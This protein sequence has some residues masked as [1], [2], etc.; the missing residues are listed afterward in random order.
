[1][2]RLLWLRRRTVLWGRRLWRR[3]RASH[4]RRRRALRLGPDDQAVSDAQAVREL[5]AAESGRR[6]ERT[7]RRRNPETW[8]RGRSLEALSEVSH[9]C[10]L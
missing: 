8:G 2:G 6:G 4:G 1:M 9:L 10:Q 5:V 7:L 3:H